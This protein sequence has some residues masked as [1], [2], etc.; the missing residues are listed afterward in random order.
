MGEGFGAE[1]TDA[2]NIGVGRWDKRIG[3]I[4]GDG[5]VLERANSFLDVGIG[6]FGAEEAEDFAALSGVRSFC[7]IE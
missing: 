7:G 1:K 4:V 3:Y 6:S 5:L 2:G